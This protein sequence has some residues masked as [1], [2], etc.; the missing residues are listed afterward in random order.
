MSIILPGLVGMNGSGKSTFLKLLMRFYDPEK[1][2]ILLNG[3][4]IK[5]YDV[6]KYRK[7]MGVA[8][9]DFAMFSA[10]ASPEPIAANVAG[11]IMKPARSETPNVEP[12][13]WATLEVS[14]VALSR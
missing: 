12:A 4:N 11:M 9:Q 8:F 14:L 2:E 5:K 7:H 13:I 1:G 6:N 3:V 10:T